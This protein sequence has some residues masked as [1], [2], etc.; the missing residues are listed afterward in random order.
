MTGFGK[1]EFN[2][3][4]ANFTIEVKSL[5]SKQ[6]DVTVKM[7]SNYREKEIDLRKSI[8]RA[9]ARIRAHVFVSQI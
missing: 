1:A 5:N 9:H 4:N 2:S 8:L 7:S 6:I 3:K